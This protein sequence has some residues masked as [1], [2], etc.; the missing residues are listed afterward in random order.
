[1]RSHHLDVTGEKHRRHSGAAGAGEFIAAS[2]SHK[3]AVGWV[4]VEPRSRKPVDRRVRFLQP[5]LA[6]TSRDVE[7]RGKG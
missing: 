2:V 6:G 7:Q 5:D 1:M 4:N 3:Q